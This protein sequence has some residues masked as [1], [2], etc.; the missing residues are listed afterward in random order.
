MLDA[1]KIRQV[2]RSAGPRPPL[3][4]ASATTNVTV[5]LYAAIIVAGANNE[6]HIDSVIALTIRPQLL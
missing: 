3:T 5:K 1:I 2:R 6:L 4:R